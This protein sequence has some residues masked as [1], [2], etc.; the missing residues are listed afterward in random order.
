MTKSENRVYNILPAPK[1]YDI[2]KMKHTLYI[3]E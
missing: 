1:E 2:P 3:Y